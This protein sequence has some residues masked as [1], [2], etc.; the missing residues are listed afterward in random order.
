MIF[1][2]D[3]ASPER[4]RRVASVA[5]APFDPLP[6]TPDEARVARGFL[7]DVIAELSRLPDMEV[8]AP[9]TSLALTP[10][11]LEP[12]RMMET[13]GVTHLLDS[14]VRPTAAGM[15][16]NVSLV[17]APTGRIVWAHRYEA[18][19]REAGAVLEEIAL[20]VANHLTARVVISR[21]AEARRRPLTSL[22]AQDCWLRGL[23]CLRRATP[24]SDEE[25]RRLFERAL[26][27]DPTY[28]R[29]YAGLSL[30]HFKRWNG[31]HATA[32][33]AE[34][35]RLGLQYVAR[36]EALDEM[37][38]VVQVVAGRLQV[39]RRNFGE[40]RR[41]LERAIELSPNRADGL[42]QMSPLWAYLG[43][44]ERALEMAAKAFRLN[45]LHEPWYYFVSIM[46]HFL[47]R[48]L[49][50]GLAILERSPPDQIF[51]QAALM[52]A[53][54]AHLGRLKEARAQ[55]PKFLQAY[56]RDIAGGREAAPEDAVRHVMDA[57]PFAREADAQFL[58]E[59]L[60]RAG[61][62][63]GQGAAPARAAATRATPAVARFTRSGGVWEADY[64]GRRAVV[65]DAKG[66]ADLALLLASPRERIHCMELAG[67]LVEGDSGAAMDAKARAACQRHIQDLQAELAEAERHN[68]F[69][70]TERISEELDAV[71]EQL[72]AAVGLGGR[73]RRLGDPAEK[74]RTAVTWR[75]RSAIRKIAE[76]HPQLG[77]HLDASVRTGAFCAY[78]PEHPV[79]WTV[80]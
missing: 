47:A 54:Y 57:N 79:R 36:A 65:T 61:L 71:I 49:E 73:S 68:D 7:E 76:A 35:D 12:R 22:R 28:A 38:P 41:H 32:Q 16:V 19:F 34:D 53:S 25:A 70:R 4:D 55:V 6:L 44:P 46:P 48:K 75:I 77:R 27:I 39:Y 67:R 59:G 5:V 13:F 56:A 8:L 18:P 31:R 80:N 17:E 43:E 15:Q 9:R 3:P 33:E 74:A 78:Q 72:S 42:M 30:S 60:A 1:E 64:A 23:E 20:Q 66:C 52:A 37:D 40:G 45:P 2:R 69:A 21:L 50:T 51:E 14:S 58:L 26:A 63:T 29:A 11:Q 24:E 10:E 62:P